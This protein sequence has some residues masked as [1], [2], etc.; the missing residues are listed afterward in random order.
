MYI[1]ENL[2][3]EEEK[4]ADKEVCLN[5]FSKCCELSKDENGN[6]IRIIYMD[7]F[8]RPVPKEQ[9]VDRVIQHIK[10]REIS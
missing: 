7:K 3:L 1:E 2:I 8:N 9:S 5:S 4:P 6:D 10:K